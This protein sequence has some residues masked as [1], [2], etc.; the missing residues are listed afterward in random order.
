MSM[1]SDVRAPIGHPN[2][3]FIGGEWVEPVV[4]RD[5]RR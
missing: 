3:F 5:D 1:T 4:R 2:R